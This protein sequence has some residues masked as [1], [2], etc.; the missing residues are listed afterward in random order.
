[1]Q[2]ASIGYGV[3]LLSVLQKHGEGKLLHF[4]V[5]SPFSLL[6]TTITTNPSLPFR[7]HRLDYHAKSG[8]NAVGDLR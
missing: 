3:A 1:M 2:P 7:P 6:H 8:Y 5:A 4:L